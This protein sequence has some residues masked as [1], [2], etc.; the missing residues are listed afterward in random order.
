MKKKN[1]KLRKEHRVDRD[2]LDSL[3]V[4]HKQPIR[5]FTPEYYKHKNV[6][7]NNIRFCVF[8]ALCMF[9]I[10]IHHA[11]TFIQE[12]EVKHEQWEVFKIEHD[13]RI[14]QK[15]DG[16]ID[17]QPVIGIATNGVAAIGLFNNSTPNKVVWLCD[18]GITYLKNR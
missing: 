7:R 15:R 16:T 13:C 1:T 9:G 8:V 14:V 18:D 2:E 6:H 12:R 5:G 3:D 10:V 11:I 4:R 17:I